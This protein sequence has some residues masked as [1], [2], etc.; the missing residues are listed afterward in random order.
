MAQSI[1]IKVRPRR[2]VV[3]FDWSEYNSLG[4]LPW[5]AANNAVDIGTS[6]AN[7][8][9]KNFSYAGGAHL[10][11]HSAGTWLVN[12]VASGLHKNGAPVQL[13]FLDAFTPG[14]GIHRSA[15]PN[16]VLG[17]DKDGSPNANFVEHIYDDSLGS[18]P[19]TASVFPNGVNVDVS[20]VDPYILDPIA[21][22]GWPYGWYQQTIVDALDPESISSKNSL[23]FV[24]APERNGAFPV[25]SGDYA[26]GRVIKISSDG[27][28][29]KVIGIQN[30]SALQ[31]DQPNHVTSTTGTVSFGMD[32]SATLTTGSPVLLTE[33]IN[34]VTAANVMSFDFKFLSSADGLL[35]V[36]VDSTL[37]FELDSQMLLDKSL[38]FNSDEIYLTTV[39][40]PGTHTL[41]LRLDPDGAEQS[42]VNISD[43]SFGFATLVPLSILGD[44][45]RDGHLD[46]AD[47]LAMLTALTDLK[48]YQASNS[49]SDSQL[50]TIGDVNGDGKVTNA[51]IQ[52]ELDLIDSAGG[53][54][55]SAIPEPAAVSLLALGAIGLLFARRRFV[56]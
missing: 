47:V 33:M 53:G 49:M 39:A 44:F 1:A 54:S 4:E 34:L 7:W 43:V 38:R 56:N 18:G 21:K 12:E 19:F 5:S 35:S 6:L 8:L 15:G 11:G 28:P 9:N 40:T 26:P 30:Q 2:D 29:D 46:P 52:A 14:F 22:H 50:L 55:L 17:F 27:T 32:H 41:L 31:L 13:T 48:D 23:G 10:I 24:H 20:A 16:P 3:T 25:Q 37:E 45:N 51:D 42:Q 36:Y